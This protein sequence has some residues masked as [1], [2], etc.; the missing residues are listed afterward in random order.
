MYEGKK[1]IL[2]CL[3]FDFVTALA[4]DPNYLPAQVEQVKAMYILTIANNSGVN[5]LIEFA[6]TVRRK[7][8]SEVSL[9]F[10]Q[11]PASFQKE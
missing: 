1:K 2:I 9:W 3:G 4:I 5:A 7:F 10:T 8:S 6:R 11:S